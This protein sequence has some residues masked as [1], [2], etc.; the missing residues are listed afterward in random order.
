MTLN[1]WAA[2]VAVLSL[3]HLDSNMRSLQMM[4]S[5]QWCAPAVNS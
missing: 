4:Q 2:M 3:W 5:Q 1:L